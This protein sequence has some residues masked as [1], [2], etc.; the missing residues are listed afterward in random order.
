MGL[1]GARKRKSG[2]SGVDQEEAY[3][4]DDSEWRVTL[5]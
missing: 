4:A 5:R 1:V 2:L 3:C